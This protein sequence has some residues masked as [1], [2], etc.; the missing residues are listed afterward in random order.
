MFPMMLLCLTS[1]A[2]K[3]NIKCQDVFCIW[4][5]WKNHTDWALPLQHP[6]LSPGRERLFLET[7]GG[8]QR[9]A[10]LSAAALPR[11]CPEEAAG[12]LDQ[13]HQDGRPWP[14]VP[15]LVNGS[16][17]ITICQGATGSFG[18]SWPSGL[19]WTM[20]FLERGRVSTL[21]VPLT[22]HWLPPH[23]HC[24]VNCGSL[25]VPHH[26]AG[27]WDPQ[28]AASSVGHASS[29]WVATALGYPRRVIS[30]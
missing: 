26:H 13:G 11:Q 20:W 6:P 29:L 9:Q 21:Q 14:R 7:A 2:E 23:L 3:N 1:M 4:L 27:T 16:H 15:S 25:L 24:L 22:S 17:R 19:A 5:L 28:T 8:W 10:V 18:S 12:M 30:I